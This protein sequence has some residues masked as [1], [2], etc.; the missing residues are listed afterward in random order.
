MTIFTQLFEKY[1]YNNIIIFFDLSVE[2]SAAIVFDILKHFNASDLSCD[3]HPFFIFYSEK[4]EINKKDIFF[5]VNE[6]QNDFEKE[7]K[8][9]VRN[10]SVIHN[11]E[12][13]TSIII[14]KY[15]YFNQIET[16]I[17]CEFD[18]SCTINI[19]FAGKSG[20]GKSSFINRLLGEKRAFVSDV[21]KTKIYNVYNH[22]YIPIKLFDSIGFEVGKTEE[23]EDLQNIIESNESFEKIMEKIHIV[24]FML[25]NDKLSYVELDFI[26]KILDAKIS[27]FLIGNKIDN[28]KIKKNKFKS[29]IN[30][31]KKFTENK[32][33]YL[34]NH[35]YFVDLLLEKDE[36]IGKIIR[37]TS[38]E[39]LESKNSHKEIIEKFEDFQ[40]EQRELL[41][42][43]AAPPIENDNLINHD[44]NEDLIHIDPEKNDMKIK[45]EKELEKL[46]SD[47]SKLCKASKFLKENIKEYRN[48]KK[49]EA[50]NLV[51]DFKR[52]NFFWGMIPLPIL[53]K[54][55]TKESR[56]K[57]INQLYQIYSPVFELIKR[58]KKE[59]KK[60]DENEEQIPR[61]LINGIGDLTLVGGVG[62][63]IAANLGY[64][65][66]ILKSTPKLLSGGL[67]IV[68]SLVISL[69]TGYKSCKDAEDL[70]IQIVK[71]LEQ[72]FVKL[73]A[74]EIY[75]DCAIKY[76]K[77]INQLEKFAEYFGAEHEIKYDCDIDKKYEDE[78]A[79]EPISP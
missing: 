52:S 75:Y 40:N 33:N 61:A 4:K 8:F 73:N 23:N 72:E 25:Q 46:N 1:E 59:V 51:S 16:N 39:F 26:N 6:L 18:I 56:L 21:S 48:K 77:A 76:N 68:V 17:N 44:N 67:G 37:D 10:I 55:M 30:Q 12:D 22:K 42:K 28:I 66:N 2:E 71:L 41:Y 54:K 65:L 9:D 60:I 38:Q 74:Y 24:Y 35:L 15:N 11:I 34:I 78:V 43:E 49:D 32:K 58:Q 53:D 31:Y 14:Q 62:I 3:D 79:P 13:I 27:I 69:G 57:M 19:L 70:G 5:K 7:Q 20:T 50:L 29:A 63:E 64:I 47:F 36:E 45:E